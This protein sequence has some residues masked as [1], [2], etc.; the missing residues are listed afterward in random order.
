MSTRIRA[1]NAV[2]VPSRLAPRRTWSI[3]SRPW[4]WAIIASLRVSFQRTARPSLRASQAQRIS[5]P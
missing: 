2:T 1:W 4:C 5:S 3:W